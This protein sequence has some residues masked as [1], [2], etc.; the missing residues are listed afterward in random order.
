MSFDASLW[1][2]K[3]CVIDQQ[4]NRTMN[5]RRGTW[6]ACLSVL[7]LCVFAD[8]S[9]A[10]G[11]G[12]RNDTPFPVIIQGSSTVNGAVRRGPGLLV[13]PG[14]VAWDNNLPKGVDRTI[15]IYDANMN[16]TVL[17]RRAIPFQGQDLFFSIQPVPGGPGQPKTLQLIPAM[18][19]GPGA[20]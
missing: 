4:G 10:A 13:P 2:Q 6:T 20:P 19:P 14:K 15:T 9:W 11:I 5:Q 18:P 12:F 1:K 7:A 3:G 16:N 17:F 8:V